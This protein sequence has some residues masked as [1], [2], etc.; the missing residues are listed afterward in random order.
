V[1]VIG[2]ADEAAARLLQAARF[3][4]TPVPFHFRVEHPGPFFRELRL[5]RSSFSARLAARAAATTRLGHAGLRV[6]QRHGLHSKHVA[7]EAETFD[8]FDDSAN[9]LW[10]ATRSTFAFGAVRDR[11]VLSKL[12]DTDRRSF[13]KVGIRS[14]GQL[15]GWAVCLATQGHD[16]KHFGDLKVGSIV[17]LLVQPGYEV[18]LIEAAVE[19]LK[20]EEVDLIVTNQALVTVRQGL[21]SGGFLRGRSNFL[22][23]ASPQLI[24]QIGTPEATL[25]HFHINRGDGDG[26]INL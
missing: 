12:Y 4:I 17:D 15:R 1:L 18:A 2:G 16:H 10:E 8:S 25:E 13:I 14:E 19:R 7:V 22:F 26:P 6:L 24:A 5:L 23:A 20:Q 3:G 11:S 21:R 9:R